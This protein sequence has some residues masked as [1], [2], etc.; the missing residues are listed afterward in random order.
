MRSIRKQALNLYQ[1]LFDNPILGRE[2]IRFLR[3]RRS[4]T[5][6]ASILIGG[7][8]LL[9]WAWPTQATG[10]Q[11]VGRKLFYLTLTGEFISLLLL[12]P[13]YAAQS[14]ISERESDTLPMLLNTPL[15]EG[16][17]FT[18]KL[19]SV[20][21][22]MMLTL[23]STYP[24]IGVCLARG[25]VAPWEAVL[26]SLA[27]L[28]SALIVAAFALYFSIN[29][30][31]LLRCIV[32]TQF[33][34]FTVYVGGAFLCLFF[35]GGALSI[36][37]IAAMALRLPPNSLAMVGGAVVLFAS[38]PFMLLVPYVMMRMGVQKLREIE[39]FQAPDDQIEDEL[40][41]QF[42]QAPAA[43][44]NGKRFQWDAPD[45]ANPFYIRELLTNL[46]RSPFIALPSWYVIAII[47]Y[48]LFLLT[49]LHQGFWLA[50]AVLI[51]TTQMSNAYASRAF[52]GERESGTLDLLLTTSSST[53]TLL[54]GKVW[55]SLRMCWERG[56]VM[57]LTPVGFFLAIDSF[58]A[59]FSLF[60]QRFH[61][62][63]SPVNLIVY[64]VAL[65]CE[66]CLIHL[67]GVYFSIVKPRV[68]QAFSWTM[69]WTLIYLLAPL[70]LMFFG[71]VWHPMLS[72]LTPIG[73][74]YEFAFSPAWNSPDGAAAMTQAF[75]VLLYHLI[76]AGALAALLW[77]GA[78]RR[79]EEQR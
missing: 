44:P 51:L 21:G 58:G 53:R 49:P 23:T 42:N 5:L 26:G 32:L 62:S 45:N 36:L 25:G 64:S 72:S 67:M 79:L 1:N 28:W 14:F 12:L 77:R 10:M 39:L 41:F 61:L 48:H 54:W 76:F 4:F 74:F 70:V 43:E 75:S 40:A 24:L 56:A 63:P 16:R 66:L 47:T 8:A 69:S 65:S 20:L 50:S 6:L 17:I 38:A 73:V 60:S 11:P 27:V 35:F 13:G 34:L 29:A 57:F 33:S 55:G 2:L 3:D 22:V 7:S 68:N 37:S 52:A 31:T 78:L 9:V 18:G 46:S 59:V 19:V 15:G 71:S 30:R